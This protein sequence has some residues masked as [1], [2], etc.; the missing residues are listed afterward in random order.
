MLDLVRRGEGDGMEVEKEGK[1]G[2][3]EELEREEG[4]EG[5]EE[6]L[7]EEEEGLI[8]TDIVEHQNYLKLCILQD[9]SGAHFW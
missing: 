4:E 9:L 6:E 5:M 1:E 8:R 2:I 7:E 3:E